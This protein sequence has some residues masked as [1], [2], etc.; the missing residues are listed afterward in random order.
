MKVFYGYK[1]ARK[2]VPDDMEKVYLDD[3]T[4]GRQERADMMEYGLQNGDVLHVFQPSDIGQGAEAYAILDALRNRRIEVKK[5]DVGLKVETR[6]R[7]AVFKPTPQQDQKC[8]TLYHSYLQM[9]HVLDRV[10]EI[11][12]QR[13]KAHHLKA[14]YGR[15]WPGTD[16]DGSGD[17]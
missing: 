3:A 9:S 1:R 12:G 11:M 7:P 6:G 4:T 17:G 13:F 5:V 2:D 8:K 14:R 10:E 15:R 16:E